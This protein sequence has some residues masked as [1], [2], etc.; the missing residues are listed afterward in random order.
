[1]DFFRLLKSLDDLLY[2]VMSWLVFYPIT[3]WRTVRHPQRMMAYADAELEDAETEQYTDTLS[4]PLFLLVSLVLSHAIELAMVG[5]SPL[6]TRMTG[7]DRLIDSD[8]SLL[9]LRGLLFSVFPLVMATRMVRR[10]KLAL[11][12]RTLRPPFYSQCYIAAPFALVMGVSATAMQIPA[13]WAHIVGIALLVVALTV[14]GTLQT[15]WFALHLG[16][17]HRRAF[18]DASIAMLGSVAMV[19]FASSLFV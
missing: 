1:M 5:E 18:V 9:V 6:V 7:F 15:R 11:T 10:Q 12:R 4:P 2:E 13:V 19:M 3:L 16:V 17:S 14:Y 8:T